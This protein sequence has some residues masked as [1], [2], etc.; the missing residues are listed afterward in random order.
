MVGALYQHHGVACIGDVERCRHTGNAPA[1]DQRPLDQRQVKG[2]Q[3]FV[4][5]HLFDD[6]A[7]RLNCFERRRLCVVLV[8]PTDLLADVGDL[9]LVRVHS[10]RL[11]RLAEGDLVH[12]RRAGR[13]DHPVQVVLA[14]GLFDQ[15]LARVGAHVF[16]IGGKGHC[17]VFCYL[18]CHALYVHRAGDVQTAMTDKDADSTHKPASQGGDGWLRY[19]S[20]QPTYCL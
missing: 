5:A 11:G 10:R 13:N 15:V 16:V 7:D 1:D 4:V 17:G 3:R 18:F 8:H 9:A 2:H 14:D 19:A 6:G 20:S 12:G